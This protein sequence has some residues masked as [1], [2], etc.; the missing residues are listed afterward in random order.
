MKRKTIRILRKTI[1]IVLGIILLLPNVP[2]IGKD[3]HK[4][5]DTG[6][7]RYSNL[8]GSYYL[9]QDFDFKSPGFSTF[10]FKYFVKNTSPA[11]ENQKLY[12]LYKIN[13]LCFWR[14]SYYLRHSIHLD[15]MAPSV[16]EKKG[17]QKRKILKI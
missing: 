6:Y 12:R 3:I 8:D 9:T 5:L 17:R 4:W 16:I 7:F 11:K 10:G 14:W 2:F 13:P 15:Y 1:V